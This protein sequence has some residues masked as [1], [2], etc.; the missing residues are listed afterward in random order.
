MAKRRNQAYESRYV[1]EEICKEELQRVKDI[2]V[3][4]IVELLEGMRDNQQ[5]E[6]YLEIYGEEIC[7]DHGIRVSRYLLMVFL[8]LVEKV[9]TMTRAAQILHLH[10]ATIQHYKKNYPVFARAVELA[11]L[12]HNGMLVDVATDFAVNGWQ[13]EVFGKGSGENAGI[14]QVGTRTKRDMRILETV[15]SANVKKFRKQVVADS[16][17]QKVEIH[18]NFGDGTKEIVDGNT[19]ERIEDVNPSQLGAKGLPAPSVDI[20]DASFKEIESSEL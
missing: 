12:R 17:G 2:L 3:L 13:E 15:L 10:H 14:E 4:E 20:H 6:E 11:Q 1:K 5:A 19:G 16:G 7:G 18:L 9:G 8:F